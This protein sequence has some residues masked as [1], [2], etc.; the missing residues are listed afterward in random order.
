MDTERLPRNFVRTREE[1]RAQSPACVQPLKKHEILLDRRDIERII[2]LAFAR[3]TRL[4]AP[5]TRG[6]RDSSDGQFVPTA[7]RF[8][9]LLILSLS[10]SRARQDCYENI[11]VET[12]S[13]FPGRGGRFSGSPLLVQLASALSRALKRAYHLA[14]TTTRKTQPRMIRM[15]VYVSGG[16]GG[17]ISLPAGTLRKKDRRGRSPAPPLIYHST[18]YQG[19]TAA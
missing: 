4:I 16:Y 15:R 9:P 8:R 11:T 14:G 1:P 3:R 12:S 19:S 7:H 13:C 18:R 17:L 6:G 5:Q 10:L 2:L